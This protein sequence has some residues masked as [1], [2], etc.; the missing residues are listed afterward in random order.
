MHD[1]PA[2]PTPHLGKSVDWGLQVGFLTCLG[3]LAEGT[4][5]DE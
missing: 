1:V 4:T 5:T 3:K 2:N